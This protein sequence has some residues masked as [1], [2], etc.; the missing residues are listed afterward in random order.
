MMALSDGV[1][2]GL[3]HAKDSQ[4]ASDSCKLKEAT[5]QIARTDAPHSAIAKLRRDM[6]FNILGP[7]HNHIVNN[8]NLKVSLDIRRRRLIELNSAKKHF[9]DV[10]KK[11]YSHTDR[12]YLQA[13]SNF[14]SA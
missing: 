12:R 14:E 4:I 5:N 3:S 1:G 6:Q 13:Q 10:T 2:S 8:R 7:V 11:Q 9:E